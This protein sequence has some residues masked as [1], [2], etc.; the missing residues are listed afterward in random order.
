LYNS[1][2]F[3]IRKQSGGYRYLVDFRSLNKHIIKESEG[4]INI[5]HVALELSYK[6]PK[7]F[8]KIDLKSGFFQLSLHPEV[9]EKTAFQTPLGK[10]EFARLPQGLTTSPCAFIR[11][12]HTL[13]A[14]ELYDSILM[15]L[16][17]LCVY[18]P[19]ISSHMQSLQNIFQKFRHARLRMS[20]EK[21]NFFLPRIS[22]LGFEV[23]QDGLRVNPQRFDAISSYPAA[24]TPKDVRSILGVYGYFRKFVPRYSQITSCLRDLITKQGSAN[25]AWNAEHD[26][27]LQTLKYELLRNGS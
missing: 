11:A 20:P 6:K 8:S 27:A 10:M 13:F 2:C 12:M 19:S 25:F 9:R 21:C 14:E 1:P 3:V 17:D 24:K 5:E 15:Y 22:F 26:F 16:D 18:S 4:V 23:S 7:Y